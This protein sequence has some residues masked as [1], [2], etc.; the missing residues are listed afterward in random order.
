M[1][2][3]LFGDTVT[4]PRG[5]VAKNLLNATCRRYWAGVKWRNAYSNI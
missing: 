1:M 2:P 3:D 4:T 5:A